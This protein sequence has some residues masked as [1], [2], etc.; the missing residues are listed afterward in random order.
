[1]RPVRTKL[2]INIEI[3]GIN[4]SIL[5]PSA[6]IVQDS[7]PAYKSFLKA[8]KDLSAINVEIDL[9]VG[10]MPDT[11]GMK[12]LF[13]SGESWFI[14]EDDDRFF[15]SLSHPASRKKTVWTA[16]FDRSMTKVTI[17][18]SERLVTKKGKRSVVSNP[19]HYPLDQLL[20]M[21]V[22]A[23]K[24]GIILHAA[25][26]VVNEKGCLFLGR[27]GAGKSTLV[28][29]C[30]GRDDFDFLS[31]DR[32]VVRKLGDG[33]KAYGT[34]WPGEAGIAT[35]RGVSLSAIFFI[36]HGSENRIKEM[37]RKEALERLLPVISISWY[38]RKAVEE[39]LDFCDGMV[40]HVPAFELYFKPDVEV[41]N[42]LRNFG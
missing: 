36:Y 23:Q 26:M 33:Y 29:L 1:M 28:R 31:D 37:S 11:E 2:S 13:D 18:C 19:F 6:S 25:G 3:A 15:L 5:C 4:F 9:E 38:D 10:F 8:E 42:V 34:P 16:L 32:I 20:L 40:S 35:N 7:D 30:S 21:Y 17:Y 41:A 27:S 24:G 12:R 14:C 39:I 22:L